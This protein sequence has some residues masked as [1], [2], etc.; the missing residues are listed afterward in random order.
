MAAILLLWCSLVQP[1]DWPCVSTT[2][3]SG[4]T[5]WETELLWHLRFPCRKSGSSI[6]ATQ[7]EKKRQIFQSSCI[8]PLKHAVKNLLPFYNLQS[9]NQQEKKH[10]LLFRI[11]TFSQFMCS[12]VWNATWTHCSVCFRIAVLTPGSRSHCMCVCVCV[13][14]CVRRCVCVLISV[15]SWVNVNWTWLCLQLCAPQL[16]P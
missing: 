11:F 16:S 5:G 8:L 13:R 4:A 9:Q 12:S 15:L 7:K 14:V 3:D 1:T 2:N 10:W 6:V